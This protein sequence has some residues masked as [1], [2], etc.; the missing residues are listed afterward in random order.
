MGFKCCGIFQG[1]RSGGYEIESGPYWDFI[2]E[3][4]ERYLSPDPLVLLN[5][6]LFDNP[7]A[8]NQIQ[9]ESSP[10]QLHTLHSTQTPTLHLIL[11]QAQ[12]IPRRH[13]P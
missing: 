11:T 7:Q 8:F 4:H 9:L 2:R 10:L 3:G 6:T 13:A 12:Q 5:S 1:L